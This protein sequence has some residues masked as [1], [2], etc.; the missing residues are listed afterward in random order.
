MSTISEFCEKQGVRKDVFFSEGVAID[1][2]EEYLYGSDV[3]YDSY[4]VRFET[5]QF[6]LL[7]TLW[8]SLLA[9]TVRSK[10]GYKPIIPSYEMKENEYDVE[11]WYDF[12]IGINGYSKSHVDSCMTFTVCNSEEDDNEWEYVISLDD[13]EAMLMYD[14]LNKE[15]LRLFRKSCSDLLDESKNEME[16]R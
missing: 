5:V 3:V 12:Y 8:L 6:K 15:C 10:E 9:D 13:D 11:G 4:P 1:S 16:D 14:V 2:Y 7:D